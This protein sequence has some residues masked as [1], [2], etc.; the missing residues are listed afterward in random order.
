MPPSPPSLTATALKLALVPTI[1]L[2]APAA[3]IATFLIFSK[4]HPHF[5]HPIRTP[6]PEAGQSEREDGYR[7]WADLGSVPPLPVPVVGILF[8]PTLVLSIFSQYRGTHLILCC[9]TTG[10]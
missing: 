5:L 1:A 2:A 3:L 7:P 4:S 8:L 9:S 6:H 10:V